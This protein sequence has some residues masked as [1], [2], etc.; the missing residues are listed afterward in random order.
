M[1]EVSKDRSR[2]AAHRGWE[3]VCGEKGG[4]LF[5]FRGQNFH[6]DFACCGHLR[7]NLQLLSRGIKKTKHHM[8][9]PPK[10]TMFTIPLMVAAAP[11]SGLARGSGSSVPVKKVEMQVPVA[12]FDRERQRILTE[13]PSVESLSLLAGAPEEVKADRDFMTAA[14]RKYWL[15]IAYASEELRSDRELMMI[16]VSQSGSALEHASE[17]LRSDREVVMT[18]VS[19][20][21]AALQYASEELRSD[22]ELVIIAVSQNGYALEH[23]SE[24]L[25]SDRD[26]VMT[27]VSKHGSA[28]RCASEELRSDRDIVMAAASNSWR[29]LQYASEDLRSDADIIASTKFGSRR[30]EALVLKAT[31]LS[32]RSCT[33]VVPL[34]HRLEDILR[35]CG[36]S[37]GLEVAA[38][39]KL[40]SSDGTTLSSL[41]ELQPAMLNEVTL[42]LT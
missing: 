38:G 30:P 13:L 23:A 29:A 2:G 35:N 18:A 24:E 5:F 10:S 9:L 37:L 1:G 26:L 16:A 17:E 8:V 36:A 22:R 3:G 6:Q 28:L 39:S 7:P 41:R 32:G 20:N 40:I 42:V 11:R 25:R 12:V 31:L 33:L 21:G 27:A 15:Y 4:G 34:P 14:V 19:K